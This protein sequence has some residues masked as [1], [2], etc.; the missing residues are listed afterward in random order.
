[1][2]FGWLHQSLHSKLH[3]YLFAVLNPFIFFIFISSSYCSSHN[4]RGLIQQ[5]NDPNTRYLCK[6]PLGEFAACQC[7]DDEHE[8]AC[9]N[10]QF[11]DTGVFQYIN[12]HYK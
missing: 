9:I 12:S 10:A 8:V 5:E 1:M 3:T 11:V 4:S 7:N 6:G 2:F